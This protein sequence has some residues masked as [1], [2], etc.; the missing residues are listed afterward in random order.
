[1]LQDP[2]RKHVLGLV[3]SL[4]LLSP[5]LLLP[6]FQYFTVSHVPPVVLSAN[7][8]HDIKYLIEHPT[9]IN[10][11]TPVY[12]LSYVGSEPLLLLA[13]LSNDQ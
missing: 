13:V 4:L 10:Q 7:G 11:I 8:I 9:R 6:L 3:F 2:P 1:M 5:A 12:H